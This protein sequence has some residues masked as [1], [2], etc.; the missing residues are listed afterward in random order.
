MVK[1]FL[2][3]MAVGVLLCAA[4]AAI[5]GDRGGDDYFFEDRGDGHEQEDRADA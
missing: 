1:A 2:A 3:G 5:F 4:I